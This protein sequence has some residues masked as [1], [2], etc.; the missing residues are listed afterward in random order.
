[1]PACMSMH[2]FACVHAVLAIMPYGY[3][4]VFL[5]TISQMSMGKYSSMTC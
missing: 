3:W 2:K 1:M 5:M 4:Y